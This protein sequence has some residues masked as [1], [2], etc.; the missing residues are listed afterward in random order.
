MVVLDCPRDAHGYDSSLN[1]QENRNPKRQTLNN[2]TRESACSLLSFSSLVL[3]WPRLRICRCELLLLI[4][5]YAGISGSHSTTPRA[6]F[7]RKKSGPVIGWS[8]VEPRHE[9]L[10]LQDGRRERKA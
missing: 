8:P 9:G 2:Q 4:C 10:Q 3:S 1:K 6:N 7:F 5:S